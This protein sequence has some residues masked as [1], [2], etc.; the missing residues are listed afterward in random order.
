[1]IPVNNQLS[2]VNQVGRPGN[3]VLKGAAAL[4]STPPT[5]QRELFLPQYV[6][7]FRSFGYSEFQA[8]GLG[9]QWLPDVLPYN[10]TRPDGYPNGRRLTDDVVD[11]L[12]SIMTRGK[13]LTDLVGPHTDYL[14]D[15][16]Y[17]GPPHPL[18]S[19]T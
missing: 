16:P 9:Q 12:V 11:D 10:Y 8:I 13:T 18:K 1:M 7:M 19:P 17:L 14:V 4:N 3:N 2:P 5:Q 6:A 15:F